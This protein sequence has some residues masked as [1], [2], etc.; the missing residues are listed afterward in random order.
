MQDYF[1]A[2]NHFALLNRPQ[3]RRNSAGQRRAARSTE[4]GMALLIAVFALLV[5]S[6]AG[7]GLL[8]MTNTEA[9]VGGNYRDAQTTYF[10]ARAGIEEAISRL[11]VKDASIKPTL[12]PTATNAQVFYIINGSW[13]GSGSNVI[14]PWDPTNKYFDTELCHE[15]DMF[16][17]GVLTNPGAT[18][19]TEPCP[20]TTASIPNG[21]TTGWWTATSSLLPSGTGLQYKWVRVTLK[22]NVSS[23]PDGG[24]TGTN[25]TAKTRYVNESTTYT[26]YSMVYWNNTLGPSNAGT[27]TM[28]QGNNTPVYMVTAMAMSPMGS[29]RM[30]QAEAT[31]L[32]SAGTTFP[33]TLE[34]T[35]NACGAITMT[36]AA[37]TDSFN[38]NLGAYG[39]TLSGGGTNISSSGSVATLGGIALQGSA[40]INGSI[41]A[42]NSN[43]HWQ[44]GK[45]LAACSG[46]GSG[47]TYGVNTTGSGTCTGGSC[48]IGAPPASTPPTPTIPTLTPGGSVLN[49]ASG[50][51]TYSPT[52]VANL[53]AAG[54]PPTFNLSHTASITF[55]GGLSGGSATNIYGLTLIGTSSVTFGPGTYNID[56][57]TVSNGCKININ[58]PVYLNITGTDGDALSPSGGSATEQVNLGGATIMN[59][60]NLA[61]NFVLSYAGSNTLTLG[62][63]GTAT[64]MVTDA[65]NAP[66]VLNGGSNYYGAIVGSTIAITNGGAFHYD[67]ALPGGG[68]GPTCLAGDPADPCVVGGGL[69]I[70]FREVMY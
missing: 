2:G 69:M 6:A 4:R 58:G 27:E 47:V 40:T 59:T 65:P 68:N 62:S 44:N 23:A 35:S 49:P 12:L 56:Y 55:S 66:V 54:K 52:Q 8:Y 60:S 45:N 51:S 14:K 70:N 42:G 31:I 7:M 11:G 3:T 46:T 63:N 9:R 5:L 26:K 48:V 64:Y 36:G 34:A 57:L 53:S 22:A 18:K 20:A 38:S 17:S 61:A 29:R 10:D 19:V 16:G 67:T 33:Y 21:S 32:P 50:T 43:F 15:G 25:G 30:L 41:S 24:D 37:T 1:K 28:T 39:A 13:T